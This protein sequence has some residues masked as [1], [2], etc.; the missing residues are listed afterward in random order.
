MAN[1][2]DYLLF[3]LKL[4]CE[5]IDH[6]GNLR[7]SDQI[8]YNEDMLSTITDTNVDVV[9]SAI[10]VFTQ[11]NMMEIMDDGTIYMSE[12][13]KMLGCETEW[14][15]KKRDYREK[16]GQCPN[17]VLPM[18]DK[19][20]SI[21]KDIDIDKDKEKLNKK[22]SGVFI[23][24]S[25]EEVKAYCQERQNNVDAETFINFYESKG[26]MVGKNKMKD[27]KAAVRTWERNNGKKNADEGKNR[28]PKIEYT[29]EELQR[30]LDSV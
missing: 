13:Q 21:D 9:R 11:L 29:E 17:S 26:W 15:A 4:L 3:Y 20:K 30:F 14:A 7:F 5:S 19:S 23:P 18:S 22:K 24:P 6:E 10:K 27:W 1:G 28:Q 25:I 2:K 12:V 8:P 16:I